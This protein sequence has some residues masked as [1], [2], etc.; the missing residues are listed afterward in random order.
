MLGD[1]TAPAQ[2][3]EGRGASQ[4]KSAAGGTFGVVDPVLQAAK[5]NPWGDPAFFP[6]GQHPAN[7]RER[8]QLKKLEAL[9]QKI[10][11]KEIEFGVLIPRGDLAE[12][13]ECGRDRIAAFEE[14]EALRKH[15][16]LRRFAA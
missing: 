11:R 15:E 8:E 14:T 5:A 12:S 2:S 1:R 13:I 7:Y 10:A 6:P 3:Q 4:V 16:Y 9:E